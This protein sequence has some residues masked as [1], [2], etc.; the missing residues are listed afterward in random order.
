MLPHYFAHY[1]HRFSRF[2][3][4][5]R[6]PFLFNQK[7]LTK[8]AA[9][10]KVFDYPNKGYFLLLYGSIMRKTIKQLQSNFVPTVA[11][12]AVLFEFAFPHYSLAAQSPEV[13][14]SVLLP[15]FIITK[16]ERNKPQA[17]PEV[18]RVVSARKLTVTAY[19]STADQTDSTPCITAN[20]FNLCENGEENVIATN[21]LPFGTKVRL[22]ELF[23]DR[24]FTV[25]DR[26]NARYYYRAD[27]WM[28]TRLAAVKLGARYTTI[29]VLE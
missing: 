15:N 18:Y 11:L 26:M 2:S 20:G 23:G 16:N 12:L 24:V 6:E 21:F 13:P 25:Q 29:E 9:C 27:V 5:T 4:I 10:D 28:K 19:S 22:P 1:Q 17:E 14:K 3:F 7:T 8:K